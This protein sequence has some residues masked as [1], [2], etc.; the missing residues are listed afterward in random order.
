MEYILIYD[1]QYYENSN[2]NIVELKS[3]SLIDAEKESIK[4]LEKNNAFKQYSNI[5]DAVIYEISNQLSINVVEK[6]DHIKKE[7]IINKS[8]EKEEKE[9]LKYE[10]LKQK[11][12]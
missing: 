8:R 12:G 5:G 10:Q 7:I 4:Y 1:D 2:T 11:Y 3:E 6:R 9:R